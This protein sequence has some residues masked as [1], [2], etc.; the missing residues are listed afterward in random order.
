M[1]EME[2]KCVG[3]G[4]V[5]AAG[6]RFC[7]KCGR[8]IA[9]KPTPPAP[10]STCGSCGAAVKP[11]DK[12]CYAC[13]KPVAASAGTVIPPAPE[14]APAESPSTGPSTPPSKPAPTS[15]EG[16]PLAP[17]PREPIGFIRVISAEAAGK[18]FPIVSD[19]V[20]IGQEVGADI[21]L[22][23]DSFVSHAHARIL[24]R[25]SGVEIEDLGSRNGTFVQIR[26]RHTLRNGDRLLIGATVLEYRENPPISH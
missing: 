14:K 10:A 18:E 17:R 21:Q 8:E 9:A 7:G 20:R 11:E 12:F 3:C 5:V 23:G 15:P 22:S 4:E 24:A 6:A 1:S 26:D 16:A 25:T 19:V 2:M 13:G